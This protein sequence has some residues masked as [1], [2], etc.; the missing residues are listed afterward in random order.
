MTR[1][2]AVVI[3]LLVGTT[4]CSD[5]RSDRHRANAPT[6]SAP[7]ATS[8]PSRTKGT[9]SGDKSCTA[10]Y[11]SLTYRAIPV[12][13]GVTR[14]GIYLPPCDPGGTRH[15]YPTVYL[16]HGA[17][18]DETQWEAI[19]LARTADRL[20]LAREIPPIIVVVPRSG[21]DAS[22]NSV[23]DAVLPWADSNLPTSAVKADRAIGGISRGGGAAFGLVARHPSLFS[24]LGGHSPFLESSSSVLDQIATWGGAVW[25][26]VGEADGLRHATEVL[27]SEL[28][29]RGA[30]PQLHVWPGGHDRDYWG[31]HLADDLR[32]YAAEWRY[33]E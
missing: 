18:A 27:A 3:V 19:G 15:R 26:D 23:V 1:R 17:G 9:V 33:P 14:L 29:S 31:A 12:E 30:H 28:E 5:A 16:F 7:A 10:E 25:L 8:E 21:L 11:G 4:A 20:I 6:T 24:R 22:D 13:G 32:F 2:A